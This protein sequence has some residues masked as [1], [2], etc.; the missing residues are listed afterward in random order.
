[1]K[2]MTRNQVVL[3]YSKSHEPVLRCQS[4]ETVVFETIDCFN[5]LL[6]A[7]GQSLSVLDEG[8]LNPATGP[9]YIY[10]AAPGDVLKVDVLDIQTET[11]GLMTADHYDGLLTDRCPEEK[12]RIIPIESGCAVLEQGL[13]LP[14]K[15]MIGVI[16]LAPAGHDEATVLSGDYGGNMDC[17]RITAGSTV[18]LPV[19][20][21][22]ALLVIGDLH[23]LMGDGETGGCGLEVSGEVTVRVTV[24][25]NATLP[26]PMVVSHG[27][28]MTVV[29]KPTLEAA[30]R[31]AIRRMHTFLTDHVAMDPYEAKYLLSRAGDLCICQIVD[32]EMTV[33]MEVSEKILDHFGYKMP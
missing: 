28:V 29:T 22:G 15:P 32:Q 4:G 19:A 6:T 11:F 13:K 14:L 2:K 18:Y 30:N 25:Q 33:R 24:I 7:E 20:T 17:K 21:E 26:V 8:F 23:A 1:M 12:V 31:E 10:G 16:G 9:L 3:T 5:G 27:Q